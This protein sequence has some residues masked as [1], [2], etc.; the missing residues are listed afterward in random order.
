MIDRIKKKRKW[1]RR[2]RKFCVRTFG[3]L[4]VWKATCCDLLWSLFQ[5]RREQKCEKMQLFSFL[6]GYTCLFFLLHDLKNENRNYIEKCRI[7]PNADK[8]KL[9]GIKKSSSLTHT[10]SYI[11]SLLRIYNTQFSDA[12]PQQI[13]YR[14]REIKTVALLFSIGISSIEIHYQ[15]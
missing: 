9:N 3:F 14:C 13:W 7:S 5:S 1:W 12:I 8:K 11:S 4:F 10:N 15:C 2:R 6:F